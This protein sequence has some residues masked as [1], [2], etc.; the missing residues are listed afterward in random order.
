VRLQAAVALGEIG[1]AA[2]PAVP[3]LVKSLQDE[4]E[5]VRHAAVFS[6][7]RIGDPSASD[8]VAKLKK[9]DNPIQN[10]LA[11]W[12]LA[13]LN[14]GDKQRMTAAVEHLVGNLG[15]EDR[16]VAHMSARAIVELDPDPA[17]LR[18]AME[19]AMAKA[20]AA[21]SQRIIAAYASLG[22]KVVPLA[23]KAL[24][25]KDANR[26]ARALMVLGRLGP[27]AAPA[28]P[29]LIAAF[30]SGDA[31]QR[32]EVLFVL[33]AIG[34]KA[35]PA[36][37]PVAAALADSDRDVMLTAGYCLG[38]IGP[39][40]KSAVPALQKMLASDD[41]MAK[42]T[43][44]WALLQIQPDDEAQ[45]KKAVPLLAE[46]LTHEREFVRIEAA[47]ALGKLGKAAASAL[48]ALEAASGDH[49]EAVRDAVAEAIQK[50]KG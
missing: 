28:V 12:T 43:G 40:A 31:K 17:I 27:D 35:A 49:S 48:P 14:P 20:D 7:G 47:M 42:L 46:A 44:A 30:K 4:L 33:G 2:K 39:G 29:D 45:G 34:P 5:A 23:I 25:D 21:T 3:A 10:T 11:L 9:S 37:E 26:R 16:D 38:K 1:P 32:T 8:A 50:I 15:G 36:V 13:R 19:A 41:K 24:N 18:P 22:P 6:L